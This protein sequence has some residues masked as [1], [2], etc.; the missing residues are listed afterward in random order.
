MS[1]T[2]TS[3]CGRDPYANGYPTLILRLIP[4]V[5]RYESVPTSLKDEKEL[6]EYAAHRTAASGF[7]TCVVLGPRDAWY[8]DPNGSPTHKEKS[9]SMGV[10]LENGRLVKVENETVNAVVGERMKSWDKSK[11]GK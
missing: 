8:C 10:M 11:E 9:P 6:I 4:G 2:A 3:R 5:Y 7:S 1:D